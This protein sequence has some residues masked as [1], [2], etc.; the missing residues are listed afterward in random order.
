MNHVEG[1]SA[2][3]QYKCEECGMCSFVFS[4]SEEPCGCARNVGTLCA[5]SSSRGIFF[6]GKGFYVTDNRANTS[7]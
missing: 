5:G 3:F 1:F 2:T 4:T 7:A 6:K